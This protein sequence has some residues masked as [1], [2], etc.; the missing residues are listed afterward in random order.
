SLTSGSRM[1]QLHGGRQAA[2][3]GVSCSALLAIALV[4][5]LGMMAVKENYVIAVSGIVI[6]NTMT[7]VTLACRNCARSARNRAGEVETWLALGAPAQR[8]FLDISRESVR[9]SLVPAIDQTKS[10][11]L[12]TLPGAFVGALMGGAPSRAPASSS[13]SSAPSC[14]P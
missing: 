10:T 9:E 12:V 2:A 5:A 8:S 3:V 6:G 7:G 11:G 13:L 4:F 14:S 1:S